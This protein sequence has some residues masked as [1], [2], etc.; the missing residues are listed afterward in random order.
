MKLSDKTLGCPIGQ[1]LEFRLVD[2]VPERK[3]QDHNFGVPNLSAR[4]EIWLIIRFL[5]WDAES[6]LESPLV[7]SGK[8]NI[9]L[10]S[11]F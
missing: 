2:V 10:V 1:E 9:S 8:V 3:R 6:R 11:A 4:H 7:V 5:H